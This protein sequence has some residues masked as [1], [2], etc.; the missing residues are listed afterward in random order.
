MEWDLGAWG[1]A[2]LA[3]MSAV[4]GVLGAL[5]VGGDASRRLWSGV[6]TLAACFG[7]GLLVSE[8]LFGWATEEEL[9]PNID[10]LSRD[11][12]LLA[13]VVTTALVVLLVRYAAR[14]RREQAVGP[15]DEPRFEHGARRRGGA[16]LR[17]R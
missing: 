12:A 14:R 3:G 13:G 4:F 8:G 2:V 6:V 5:L 1:L 11:E 7:V 9:Q 10:G 17:H 15:G 16:H